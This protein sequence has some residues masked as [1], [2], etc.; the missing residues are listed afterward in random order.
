[1]AP[2]I[3][4]IPR[5]PFGREDIQAFAEEQG[6]TPAEVTVPEGPIEELAWVLGLVDADSPEDSEEIE[7]VV[8]HWIEDQ[9]F[10][11]DYL[12]VEGDDPESFADWLRGELPLHSDQSLA[13]LT[14]STRDDAALMRALRRLG[15]N[16]A[17]RAFDSTSYGLLRWALH[18]PEPLVRRNALLAASLLDWPEL[19][20]LLTYVSE[21]EN[22]LAV[23][24]QALTTLDI[25]RDSTAA[26]LGGSGN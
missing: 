1:M 21:T 22:D 16:Y 5:G 20:P 11:V 12:A 19:V 8:V 24:E 2:L 17:G 18:D 3:Q 25:V 10:Q 6:W 7:T 23:R 14:A 26:P 9:R 13:Q 15:V 4:L